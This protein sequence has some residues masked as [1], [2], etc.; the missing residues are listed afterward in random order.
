MVYDP[1]NVLLDLFANVLLRIFASVF[2]S[3]VGQCFVLFHFV[4]FL[5]ASLCGLVLGYWWPHRMSLG[6]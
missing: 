4:L 1:S 6:V 5:V 3:D 2:I